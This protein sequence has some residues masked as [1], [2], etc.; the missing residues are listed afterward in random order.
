VRTDRV[1]A[2]LATGDLG[3]QV[4]RGCDNWLFFVDELTI[5]PNRAA[6]FA[7]RIKIV[8]EAAAFLKA[9]NI[10]FAL[11]PVPDKSRVEAAH[12]CGVDRPARFADRFA[13]FSAALRGD[14]INVV[15][16][17][18]PMIAASSERYYRTDT[19]WNENGAKIASTAVA[20]ALRQWNMAPDQKATFRVSTEPL[21]ERIGDLIG[22]AG[23]K[24]VP[25]PLRPRGDFVS[26]TEIEQSAAAGTG[27]LDETPPPELTLVGTSFSNSSNF[28]PF[29][30]LA[31]GSPVENK[32]ISGVGI[33]K[34]A[35]SYFSS[36]E[37][38]KSPPRVVVWEI[39]ERMLEQPV[40]AADE[41]WA[42]NLGR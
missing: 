36:S 42:Q 4:R 34:A 38:A 14:G 15:D 27:L 3:N 1:V 7:S 19:H 2:W 32:A 21:R 41:R 35:M 13:D 17:L 10:A 11:V 25:W 22:L 28:A 31:I 16:V 20:A 8:E 24:A 33:T 12:L 23:L 18:A 26:S 29:L 6:N 37:F 39:P 30:A 40:S 9:R 5:Y